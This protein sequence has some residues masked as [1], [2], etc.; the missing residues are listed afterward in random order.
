[1]HAI[2]IATAIP[3]YK[4]LVTLW[5]CPC[6]RTFPMVAWESAGWTETRMAVQASSPKIKKHTRHMH[7]LVVSFNDY[8]DRIH[9]DVQEPIHVDHMPVMLK[10]SAYD[11]NRKNPHIATLEGHPSTKINNQSP[12]TSAQSL[13]LANL[14]VHAAGLEPRL[15]AKSRRLKTDEGKGG[16]R[17]SGYCCYRISEAYHLILLVQAARKLSGSELHINLQRLSVWQQW[18]NRCLWRSGAS[19]SHSL[20]RWTSTSRSHLQKMLRMGICIPPSR[21]CS[22]SWSSMRYRW[23]ACRYCV[24]VH[25]LYYV[26]TPSS[27]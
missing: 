14:H 17:Q 16:G 19:C 23:G 12:R 21:I 5:A 27:G 20:S 15:S 11:I 1:M 18:R 8:S 2:N 22:A 3:I 9:M 13:G 24:L 10:R 7:V 25:S 26:H 4:T 6:I